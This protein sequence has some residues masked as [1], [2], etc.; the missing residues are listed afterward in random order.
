MDLR[1]DKDLLNEYNTNY[2]Y[3]VSKQNKNLRN[4]FLGFFRGLSPYNLTHHRLAHYAMERPT[5]TGLVKIK[6]SKEIDWKKTNV[7]ILNV[8]GSQL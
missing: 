1:T 7:L 3:D 6:F 4:K 8:T 5:A 2:W